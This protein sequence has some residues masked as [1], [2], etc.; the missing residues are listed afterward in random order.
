MNLITD[1]MDRWKTAGVLL[2]VVAIVGLIDNTFISWLFFGMVYLVAF[3]EATKLFQATQTW[4]FSYALLIWIT[5]GLYPHPSDIMLFALI[6]FAGNMAFSKRIE[7]QGIYPLLYPTAGMLF[8]WMLY[9]GYGM[10]VLLWMLVIVA[11]TDVGAF[12]VGKAIGKTSFCPTSPNKTWEGVIGG[13]LTG[14]I[15]G[16]LV[17]SSLM[18][19]S[20]FS[21]LLISLLASDASIFGDLFESWLKRRAGVKD[22]GKFLPGHGGA[23]DRIDGYLFAGIVMFIMLQA[24]GY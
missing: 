19:I 7:P 4:L 17:G 23:L 5:A 15:V 18:E 14:T 24:L 21:A 12:F 22:S 11:L 1:H 9:Q 10:N 3:Y 20:F 2:F 8:I 6:L 13:F 16:A